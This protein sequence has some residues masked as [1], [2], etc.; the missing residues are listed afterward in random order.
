[1]KPMPAIWIRA[2]TAE[3]ERDEAQESLRAAERERDAALNRYS[4]GE[5]V[6]VQLM[7]LF[8][9]QGGTI[10]QVFA[11]V[12][13]LIKS[14][15]AE[16]IAATTV[17]TVE[18]TVER[19]ARIAAPRNPDPSWPDSQHYRLARTDA[20]NAIRRA[21]PVILGID[22]AAGEDRTVKVEIIGKTQG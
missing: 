13:R 14:A 16:S 22:P 7:E 9:W 5:P 1:M 19:C 2:I 4:M 15:S 3:R 17:A 11:E 6:I 20:A 18:A 8:G 21:V 12:K 10:H